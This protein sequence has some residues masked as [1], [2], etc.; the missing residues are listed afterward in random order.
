[1]M[2]EKRTAPRRRVLKAG[3][4]EVGGG[5]IDCTVR[6]LS[7]ISAALDVPSVVGIPDEFILIISS[8]VLRFTCRVVWRKA[9]RMGVRFD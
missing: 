6:N 2:N 9:T 4:I 1:M 7:N 8:D 3:S 5:T